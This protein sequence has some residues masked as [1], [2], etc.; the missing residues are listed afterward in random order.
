MLEECYVFLDV[1][2]SCWK[3]LF[4]P[5]SMT[6]HLLYSILF[7]TDGN[8]SVWWSQMLLQES[9]VAFPLPKRVHLPAGSPIAVRVDGLMRWLKGGVWDS[10]FGLLCSLF[11]LKYLWN[12]FKKLRWRLVRWQITEGDAGFPRLRRVLL[13]LCV[14]CMLSLLTEKQARGRMTLYP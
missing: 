10:F 12:V 5:M 4:H 3:S 6:V 11:W 7:I 2:Q 9:F 13:T 1:S 8:K 14:T